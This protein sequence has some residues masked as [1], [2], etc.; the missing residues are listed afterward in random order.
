MISNLLERAK[1]K[2]SRLALILVGYSLY[3][4]IYSLGAINLLAECLDIEHKILVWNNGY[5]LSD[6]DRLVS[7]N[8]RM[9]K[10]SNANHEFSGWQEGLA[11]LP[12]AYYYYDYIIFVNDSLARST[13]DT[14]RS[15]LLSSL[16]KSIQTSTQA[17][18]IGLI[19]YPWNQ[20]RYLELEGIRISSWLCTGCFALPGICLMKLDGIIDNSKTTESFVSRSGKSILN[21]TCPIST[22]LHIIRWLTDVE[23][24]WY[25]AL[26]LPHSEQDVLILRYKAKMILNELTLSAR[27]A[28]AGFQLYDPTVT[29]N[30]P[31]PIFISLFVSLP[32]LILRRIL[33]F[34]F[35]P[36]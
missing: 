11:C 10:G 26:P 30:R 32:F 36:S 35:A 33:V 18:A 8:W 6:I 22:K 24:G 21:D 13:S 20:P 16:V 31:K 14:R 3:D 19:H 15:N 28:R 7:S 17:T 1:G 29:T 9:H 4:T 5:S 27:L 12:N 25:G 23:N 2:E 34:F